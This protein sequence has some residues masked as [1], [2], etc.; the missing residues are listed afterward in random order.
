M[1]FF[2]YAGHGVSLGGVSCCGVSS[3]QPLVN[4]KGVR[5]G[6]IRSEA[7]DKSPT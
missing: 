1:A 2:G 5:R 7:R 4:G 3:N 6:G